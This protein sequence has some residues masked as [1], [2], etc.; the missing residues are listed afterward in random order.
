[1]KFTIIGILTLFGLDLSLGKLYT[2]CELA[3]ELSTHLRMD[4]EEIQNWVC[5]A[6][7]SSFDTSRKVYDSSDGHYSHGLFLISDRWWCSHGEDRPE[8]NTCG[9]DCSELRSDNIT[10][11]VNCA[12]KIYQ[13]WQT[14]SGYEAWWYWPKNCKNR[15]PDLKSCNLGPL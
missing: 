10:A 9:V 4:Y 12:R 6:Q 1:M 2:K 15:L 5:I 7:I 14:G 13:V 3:R 11:S 8:E